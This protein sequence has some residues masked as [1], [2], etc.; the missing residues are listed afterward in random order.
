MHHSMEEGIT[1][2]ARKC[3]EVG[4]SPFSRKVT[5]AIMGALFS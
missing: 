1:W 5:G 2:G 4:L 3:A